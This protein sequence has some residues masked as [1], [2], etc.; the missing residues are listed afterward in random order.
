MMKWVTLQS[1]S[2]FTKLLL[3]GCLLSTVPVIILGIFSYIRSSEMLQQQVDMEKVQVLAQVQ[4]NVEQVLET[5]THSVT[6][7]LESSLMMQAMDSPI[8]A[9]HFEIYNQLTSELN[10]LQTFDT[11]I[12]DL[13]LLNTKQ[14]WLID[15]AG[16][17][18]WNQIPTQT[19]YLRFLNSSSNRYWTLNSGDYF[20]NDILFSASSSEPSIDYIAKLPFNRYTPYG[21]A[22][23]RIPVS[24]LLRLFPSSS[25]VESLLVLDQNKQIVIANHSELL[26]TSIFTALG[27]RDPNGFE[28]TQGQFTSE[29]NHK[30]EI[31]TYTRSNLNG[32]TYVSIIP[33]DKFT[34]EPKQIGWFTF[35]L[36]LLILLITTLAAWLISKKMVLPLEALFQQIMPR[37]SS[38]VHKPVQNEFQIIGD[39]LNYLH[40]TKHQLEQQLHAHVSQ[41]Q[42]YFMLKLFQGDI[43]SRELA[44]RTRTFGILDKIYPWTHMAVLTTQIDSLKDTHYNEQDGYLLLFAIQNILEHLIPSEICLPPTLID[45]SQVTIIGNDSKRMDVFMGEL[46]AWAGLVQENVA[47]YLQLKISIG[48]SRPFQE[49]TEV[50]RAY[51]EGL[52]ALKHRMR[53]GKSVIVRFDLLLPQQHQLFTAYPKQLEYELSD[54]IKLADRD[55]AHLILDKMLNEM[56]RYDLHPGVYQVPLVRLVNHLILTMEDL[57]ITMAKV[58]PHHHFLYDRILK[59]QIPGEIEQLL[60]DEIVDPI[61]FSLAVRRDSLH[62]SDQLMAIVHQEY[63]TVLTLERCAER[64]HYNSNYLSTIFR[65]E[66]NTS[67]TE[68]LSMYRCQIAKKWLLETDDSIKE[69]SEKLHYQNSQNFIRSF[70]KSEGITP[71]E[72]RKRFG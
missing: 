32:W 11:G 23:V 26:G 2:F 59:F 25:D 62:L 52:E 40:L 5:V 4:T 10:H 30:P 67:F 22:I 69:I 70:R 33:L 38:A 54:A 14:N 46:E 47:R 71:G 17:H 20:Q 55:K 24:N 51:Q 66:T 56:F 35:G 68:Y 15:N 48:I 60:K 41:A 37:S 72:F 64:L 16:F 13:I 29:L 43:K 1:A 50:P 19:N 61:I 36:C 9:E 45:Q 34:T 27:L 3:F 57:G 39:H 28:Q 31:V 21:L 58:I 18:Y 49:L 44:E 7:M 42:N 63:D 6:Y 8:D 53:L 12:S 65:K